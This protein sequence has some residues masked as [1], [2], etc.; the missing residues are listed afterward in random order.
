MDK[1]TEYYTSITI[2]TIILLSTIGVPRNIFCH[3]INFTYLST[4][5]II[6]IA[7]LIFTMLPKEKVKFS[8]REAIVF[9]C[10]FI[11]F[12][13]FQQKSSLQEL[14][15][16]SLIFLYI[17]IRSTHRFNYKIIIIFINCALLYL[18]TL[19]YIQYLQWVPSNN[20]L[21]EI[22]GPY[23]NPAILSAMIS[24]LLGVII[25]MLIY[26]PRFKKRAC[27]IYPL[28]IIIIYC[29]PLLFVTTSRSAW[30]A[31]IAS[32]CY[33]IYYK[34]FSAIRYKTKIIY[35]SIF[36]LGIISLTAGLYFIKTDSVKGRMLIWKISLDMIKD[37]PITGFGNEGFSGNY[38]YYQANYIKTKATEEEKCLAG[39]THLAFNEPLRIAVEHGLP[40]ALCYFIFVIIF[41]FYQAP[42]NN[43]NVISRAL[44]AGVY[45]WGLFSYP[46]QAFPIQLLGLLSIAFGLNSNINK[47]HIMST[48]FRIHPS[49]YIFIFLICILA[50]VKLYNR[51]SA[52]QKLQSHL[53]LNYNSKSKKIPEY[54]T[55]ELS[56]DYTFAHLYCLQNFNNK[57]Y[58]SFIDSFSYLRNRF[59]T[60][61]IWVMYGDYCNAENG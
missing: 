26:Y 16:T 37:K 9:S 4:S 56:N 57:D 31:F 60:P 47:Q 15:S 12:I 46:N 43:V 51:W 50:G 54:I 40:S 59:P 48:S 33:G 49:C 41:L 45:I 8:I 7:T 28:S 42:E 6:L 22:T 23:H 53:L 34:C 39:N 14:G 36:V 11:Y 55:K 58:T 44:F 2:G 30:V 32:I 29:V 13:C 52:Y 25:N 18:T 24:L 27:I 17:L 10:I 1:K 21:Y 3:Q 61:S 19:G 38:L 5:A 35:T 20:T